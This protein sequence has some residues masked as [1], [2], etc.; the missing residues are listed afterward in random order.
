MK[1]DH[2][3]GHPPHDCADEGCQ[4]GPTAHA[5]MHGMIDAI[6]PLAIRLPPAEAAAMEKLEKIAGGETLP[7][8]LMGIVVG[9]YAS[10]GATPEE[11]GD[12]ATAMARMMMQ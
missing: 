5:A 10:R 11:I 9:F 1:H 8:A 7:G 6:A 2:E 4:M 3:D 12:A